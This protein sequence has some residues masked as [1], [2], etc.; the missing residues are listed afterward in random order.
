M[1]GGLW[2]YNRMEPVEIVEKPVLDEHR[3]RIVTYDRMVTSK[4][5]SIANFSYLKE[6]GYELIGEIG[7]GGYGVV[8]KVNFTLLYRHGVWTTSTKYMRSK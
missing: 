1:D 5:R 3:N 6:R 4:D 2:H 8:Y 7:R